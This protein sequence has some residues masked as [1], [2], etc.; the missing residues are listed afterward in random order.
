MRDVDLHVAAH[1]EVEVAV[2]VGIEEDRGARPAVIGDAGGLGPVPERAG[3][4][5]Q[6]Q[7]VG[8]EV[9]DVEVDV[10][11]PVR[12]PGR[13]AHP[14]ARVGGGPGLV[15]GVAETPAAVAHEEP[16]DDDPR[17]ALRA[18]AR[19]REPA[20]LD[21]VE[22]EVAVPIHVADRGTRTHRFG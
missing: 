1:V 21:E 9:R 18:S 7:H 19:P 5:A 6:E 8:P 15:R 14:I 16:I 12:V 3:S 4:V 10:S 17:D 2:P 20:A 22:V 13:D 11:V